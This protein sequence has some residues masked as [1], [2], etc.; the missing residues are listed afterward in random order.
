MPPCSAPCP[1][2]PPAPCTPLVGYGPAERPVAMACAAQA[3]VVGR[4]VPGQPPGVFHYDP[5]HHVLERRSERARGV[6]RVGAGR[7][8]HGSQRMIRGLLVEAQSFLFCLRNTVR[9]YQ[10]TTRR[11]V[12]LI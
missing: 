10:S 11:S 4:A 12:F 2:H 6:R 5:R 9:L 1:L 8:R 7:V 3:Y